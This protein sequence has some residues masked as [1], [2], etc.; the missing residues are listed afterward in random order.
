MTFLAF[1]PEQRIA[2]FWE[3][4]DKNGPV[5]ADR[6]ELGPCW[7]WTAFRNPSGYGMVGVSGHRTALA[8][9]IAY[10]LVVGAV[11]EGLTLDHLCRN[12]ACVNPSHLEPVTNRENW[13][14]GEAPSVQNATKTH[15]VN[16]HEFT[17]DNTYFQIEKD[18][19]NRR[20]CKTCNL[21]SGRRWRAK[22]SAA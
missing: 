21:E 9:R 5:P 11:P 18:G 20:R 22:R 4:V 2:A 14:R 7:V 6:P 13:R 1:T 12:R 10:E 16:D 15:C 17:P 3:K 19:S 8:H